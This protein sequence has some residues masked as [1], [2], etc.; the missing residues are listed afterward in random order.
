MSA[1]R[2]RGRVR[3]HAGKRKEDASLLTGRGTYI[4][5]IALAGHV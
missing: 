3:R 2:D 4:D 1:H 5:N